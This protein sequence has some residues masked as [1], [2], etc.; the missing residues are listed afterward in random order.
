[1][2]P[3]TESGS[4][5]G[6]GAITSL[7]GGVGQYESGQQT[8]AADDYNAQITLQNMR[9]KMVA[10]KQQYQQ[11]VGKQASTYAAAGVDISRGS[12]LLVMA[13]TAGRGA[14]QGEAIEQAGTEEANLEEYY[15]KIAAFQGTMGG[16]GTFLSGLSK[17][18]AGYLSATQTFSPTPDMSALASQIAGS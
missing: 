5:F 13:A 2:T 16:I 9:A 14:Q 10:N 7:L 4:L 8:K 3:Q 15:G 17:S 12:P 11:L 6:L 18:A 1:M